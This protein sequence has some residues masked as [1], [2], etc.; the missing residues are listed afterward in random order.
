MEKKYILSIGGDENLLT[1]Q[2]FSVNTLDLSGLSP[3]NH[4]QSPSWLVLFF[5]LQWKSVGTPGLELKRTQNKLIEIWQ[6]ASVK[7]NMDCLFFPLPTV[8]VF[9]RAMY[10]ITQEAGGG[11]AWRNVSLGLCSDCL[12]CR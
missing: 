12:G 11:V 2:R 9:F 10:L 5:F 7:L 6:P 8:F 1:F 4:G 3:R